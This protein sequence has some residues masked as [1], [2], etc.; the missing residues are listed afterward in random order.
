MNLTAGWHPDPHNPGLERWWDGQQWG[1]Q[2]RPNAALHTPPTDR[3]YTANLIAALVAS[4]GI[5]IGSLGPWASFFAFSKSGV[6]GD[7]I[8]TLIL[9]VVAA[10][11]LFLRFSQ[12]ADVW[13]ALRWGT[14]VVGVICLVIAIVDI[15]N[16]TSVTGEFFGETVG[17]QIGWGLWLLLI[18][19]AALCLTSSSIMKRPPKA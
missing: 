15:M 14:P 18:S 6:D 3:R 4:G 16:L 10:V 19:S 13:A 7:G 5:V 11:S 17:V 9:G 1:E 12:G 8:I 2:T